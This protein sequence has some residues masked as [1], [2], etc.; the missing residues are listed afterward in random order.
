V[1]AGRSPRVEVV[2]TP[3]CHL[4]ESACEVVDDVCAGIG[5]DW[6]AVELGSLAADRQN[7]WRNYVPV[8][9]IDGAVHDIFRVDPDRLRQALRSL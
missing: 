5:I 8:I 2:V 7:E 6:A 3:G 9:L 1:T 4:C